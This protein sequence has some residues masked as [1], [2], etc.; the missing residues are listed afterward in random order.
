MNVAKS[1]A[2]S[3]LDQSEYFWIKTEFKNNNIYF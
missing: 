1:V 2:A 3:F